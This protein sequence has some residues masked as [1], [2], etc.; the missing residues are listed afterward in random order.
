MTNP[1][2]DAKNIVFTKKLMATATRM[3]REIRGFGR[4]VYG[5]MGLVLLRAGAWSI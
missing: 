5:F 3:A 4:R 2:A 1:A